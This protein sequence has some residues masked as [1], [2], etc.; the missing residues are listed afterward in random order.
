MCIKHDK[1]CVLMQHCALQASCGCTAVDNVTHIVT[2][3]SDVAFAYL[4]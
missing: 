1:P 4:S 2:A 3:E